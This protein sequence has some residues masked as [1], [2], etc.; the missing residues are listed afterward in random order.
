MAHLPP[1]DR[2]DNRAACAL[3][4]VQGVL[5][6]LAAAA[7]LVGTLLPAI[8]STTDSPGANLGRR[9]GGLAIVLAL[10]LGAYPVLLITLSLRLRR[11]G[12]PRDWWAA[13][14]VETLS[15]GAGVVTV[16]M[17]G[18]PGHPVEHP[19]GLATRVQAGAAV[20]GLPL[21]TLV[22]LLRAGTRRFHH[23][24]WR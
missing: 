7:L 20:A 18:M 9:L 3:L 23:A 15:V 1:R 2:S 21:A 5:T 10:A 6:G 19:P 11:A 16:V 24:G 8:V 4:M 12:R 13:V 22:F 17:L 14:A